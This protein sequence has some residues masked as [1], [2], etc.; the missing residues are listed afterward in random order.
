MPVDGS[1]ADHAEP[2]DP[3]AMIAALERNGV[4]VVGAPT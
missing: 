3:A 2:P 1:G 4:H